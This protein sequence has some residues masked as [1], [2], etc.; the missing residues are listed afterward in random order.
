MQHEF[1]AE[2]NNCVLPSEVIKNQTKK[3][4]IIIT[5]LGIVAWLLFG[6]EAVNKF[7]QLSKIINFSS[8]QS[9]LARKPK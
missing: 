8:I 6:S 2:L 1:K 3:H 9:R 5:K 4:T 7:Q